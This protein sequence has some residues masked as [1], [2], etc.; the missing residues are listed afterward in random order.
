M[1]D[2]DFKNKK[3]KPKK[4]ITAEGEIEISKQ[5]APRN[6]WLFVNWSLLTFFQIFPAV[7]RIVSIRNWHR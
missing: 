5:R 1:K 3:A 6:L 7:R 4:L 2:E